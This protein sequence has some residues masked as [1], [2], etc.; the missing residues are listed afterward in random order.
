MTT[1]TGTAIMRSA[2]NL[3]HKVSG[4]EIDPKEIVLTKWGIW[5]ARGVKVI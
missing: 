2:W 3:P 5:E 1:S 4:T